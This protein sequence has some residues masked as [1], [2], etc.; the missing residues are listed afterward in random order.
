MIN[1]FNT[2]I[3]TLSVH[4][5][6]N[7]SRNEAFFLS[8]SPYGLN[9]E[10]MPLLKE[11]F[12]KSF[13]EKEE[14]YFQFAHDVDLEY[15]EMYNFAS[16]IFANPGSVHEVSKKITKH[17]FEQSNHPHIKNGEVYVA[18]LTNLS[19]DNNQVDAVGVFKSELQSDFLQFEENG[20][21]LEM[22]LQ[23]GI[24][25]N[26]L[27][28]G[29]LIFNHKKEEGY[30]ILT[31]D[32]NRYDA[33]Y[34]LEHFLSVDAFQDENFITKKYLKFCQD[35]AKDVV[36]PAED[37]KEEVMFMNRSVN[38]FAKNDDFV[39]QNFLNEVID[40]PDLMSE[41]KNYKVDK[42]EKYSIED[43]T[44]FPIANAAVSDARKK[45]KNVINLDTNIQIKLDFINPESAEK[46]VE[47]G[48]DEE[49]QMYYYLVYFNKEQKS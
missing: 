38:Y 43:V 30:K 8:E 25:L 45:I 17:L 40:N 31:V 32:S 27:D 34:W 47:K 21:N 7:K 11:F 48:W 2:H 26:K 3:E 19:I 49:K 24:N 13:R 36:L 22:I 41:F 5:V 42:G 28:K 1:L 20:S 35:F 15:N 18:Y 44:T 6:G 39:E 9:D 16:E 33:R 10:I 37:K 14:N 46:F 4:R 12:F 29:C 23:H